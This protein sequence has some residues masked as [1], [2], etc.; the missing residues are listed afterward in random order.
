VF[1]IFNLG[2]FSTL[3]EILISFHCVRVYY[4]LTVQ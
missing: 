1:F 2:E 4:L 3:L